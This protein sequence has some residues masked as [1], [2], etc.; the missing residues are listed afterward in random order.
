MDTFKLA[1]LDELPELPD[2]QNK[3]EE[4]ELFK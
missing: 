3:E 4:R 1:S 2:Y